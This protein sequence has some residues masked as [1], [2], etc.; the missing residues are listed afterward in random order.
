MQIYISFPCVSNT[1]FL[2]FK[3]EDKKQITNGQLFAEVVTQKHSFGVASCLAN[4]DGST[5]PI[6]QTF[7]QRINH[8][9]LVDGSE[10]FV[11]LLAR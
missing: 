3:L 6:S 9:P 4:R 7:K 5:I 10:H 8:L 2:Q 1:G 11:K